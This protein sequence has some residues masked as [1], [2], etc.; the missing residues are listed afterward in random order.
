MFI[1]A[2]KL[3]QVI[4]LSS[5]HYSVAIRGS[6]GNCSRYFGTRLEMQCTGRLTKQLVLKYPDGYADTDIP[7]AIFAPNHLMLFVFVTMYYSPIM[8]CST[9]RVLD[10]NNFEC[11]SNDKFKLALSRMFCYD[12]P[13]TYTAALRDNCMKAKNFGHR[14]IDQSILQYADAPCVSRS[15]TARWWLLLITAIAILRPV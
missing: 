9:L 6:F 5:L 1:K 13:L 12:K 2:S 10:S 4:F 3:L 15:E 14:A 7:Y 8:N 11:D